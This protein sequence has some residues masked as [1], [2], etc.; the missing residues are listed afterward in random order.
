MTNRY[1]PMKNKCK[2]LAVFSL[3]FVL[4]ADSYAQSAAHITADIAGLNNGMIIFTYETDEVIYKDSVIA[5]HGVFT[6]KIAMAE[7]VL[8]TLSNSVNR[9]IRI[10]LIDHQP[11]K[12][13][14]DVSKFY[15]LKISG[16][17][18]HDLLTQYKASLYALPGKRPEATADEEHD[19][20]ARLAFAAQQQVLKDS[21]LSGFVRAYP[22][23]TAAAIAVYDMYVT[24]PDRDKALNNF[25]LLSARVRQGNYGRMIKTFTDAKVNTENGA[26]AAGFSLPDKNGKVFSLADFRGKYVLIDF[27]ASWCMPCRKENPNLIKAYQAYHRKGFTIVGLSMDSSAE[28]WLTAVEQD[29]LPWLQLNDPKSTTGKAA[30]IYG[31]KSLPANFLVGPG[32]KIVAKNLRGDALEKKLKELIH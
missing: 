21:V 7:P 12:I 30:N 5:D 18:E 2:Y 26:V 17:E 6:K 27:W 28:N 25:N 32:G 24:Y 10:L 22:Q 20:K 4:F 9:Q 3:C 19:K 15:E 8:C 14:G 13:S 31:V 11:A 16:S 23:H 1:Q 29:K